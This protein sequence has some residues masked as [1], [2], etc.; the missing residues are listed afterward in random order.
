MKVSTLSEH[1]L[2]FIILCMIQK[3]CVEK[4]GCPTGLS[5]DVLR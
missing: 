2:I 5:I 3:L 4:I 1:A